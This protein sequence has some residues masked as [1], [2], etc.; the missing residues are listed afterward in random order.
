MIRLFLSV[1]SSAIV[2]SSRKPSCLPVCSHDS[3]SFILG[4]K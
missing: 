1:R 4:Q 2:Y 3:Q